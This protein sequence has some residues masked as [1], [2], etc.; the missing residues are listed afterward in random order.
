[1]FDWYDDAFLQLV[2]R[3]RPICVLWLCWFAEVSLSWFRRFVF[4]SRCLFIYPILRSLI[5]NVHVVI[6]I[7]GHFRLF[8]WNCK[9]INWRNL[10]AWMYRLNF[11]IGVRP[12]CVRWIID[13]IIVVHWLYILIFWGFFWLTK[14]RTF[15]WFCRFGSRILTAPLL[16]VLMLEDCLAGVSAHARCVCASE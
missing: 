1:M 13:I 10:W 9:L 7:L 3:W 14:C 6:D 16:R 12:G 4:S 5:Y 15:S 8:Q 11:I 2:L